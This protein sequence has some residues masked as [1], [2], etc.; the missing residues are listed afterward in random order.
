MLAIAVSFV[1]GC[2]PQ[3]PTPPVPADLS[4]VSSLP[5]GTAIGTAARVLADNG[6]DIVTSDATAGLLSA[7]RIRETTG[8]S[9][10]L[11]CKNGMGEE[12]KP[13][14]IGAMYLKTTVTVTVTARPE[15][16]GSNVRAG[17]RVTASYG[18][19]PIGKLPDSDTDCVSSGEI[20]KRVIAALR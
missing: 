10:Y 11:R 12:G 6:F 18:D 19:N 5:V 15:G 8:N 16:S 9:L 13:Q 20:E 7:R 17:G 2:M 4:A 3:S 14:N 1:T